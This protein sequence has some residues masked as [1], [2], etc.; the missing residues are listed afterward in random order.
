[1]IAAIGKELFSRQ[2]KG[3]NSFHSDKLEFVLQLVI[4]RTDVFIMPILHPESTGNRT[5]LY[6]TK[7]LIQMAGMNIALDHSIELEDSKAM[8]RG[9]FQAVQ[10]QFLSDVKSA[11][12]RCYGIARV[13]DMAATPDIVRMQDI[14]ADDMAFFLGHA[15]VGLSSEKSRSCLLSQRFL[16]RKRNAIL[17]HFVPNGDHRGNVK[18]IQSILGQSDF[19]T[20]MDRYV[21]PRD[22]KKQEAIKNVSLLLQS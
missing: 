18:T 1:M 4:I 5:K 3:S 7:P 11:A 17:Y 22:N 21:H 14:E 9:L 2:V 12:G 10:N 8:L 6:K 13:A 19:K 20:T 16:L 15:A